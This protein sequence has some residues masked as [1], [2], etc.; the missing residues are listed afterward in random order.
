MNLWLVPASD[1]A[2][3]ANV[4]KTLAIPIS[5]ERAEAAGIEVGARAWGAKASS[6]ASVNKFKKMSAEIT[7]SFTQDHVLEGA[8]ATAGKV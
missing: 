6:D 8:N 7:A 1:D 4:M 5:R 2:A 3:D